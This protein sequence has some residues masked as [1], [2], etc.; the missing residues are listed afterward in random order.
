VQRHDLV[1]DWRWCDRRYRVIYDGDAVWYNQPSTA[2]WLTS[3][4]RD[5]RRLWTHATHGPAD[6][7][8][9]AQ[10]AYTDRE[11]TALAAMQAATASLR[12]RLA[13]PDRQETT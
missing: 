11:L 8:G 13:I 2:R 1:T 7:A 6:V 12:R 5:G 3:I 10:T 9:F 4:E